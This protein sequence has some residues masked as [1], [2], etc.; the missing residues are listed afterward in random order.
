MIRRVFSSLPSFKELIFHGGL[1]IL[2]ADVT[3]TSGDKD[4]RNGTGKSSLI[5]ILHLLLGSDARPD[6]IFRGEAL[7]SYT[8]GME[9][10]VPSGDGLV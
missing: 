1:N 7:A 9:F 8:F 3:P 5:E 10:D 6:S 4:T 2:I